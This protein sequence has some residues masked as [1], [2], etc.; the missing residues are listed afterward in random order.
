MPLLHEY[1]RDFLLCSKDTEK[2]CTSDDPTYGN[3]KGNIIGWS[4]FPEQ[5]KC[6]SFNQRGCG[7][8]S[9]GFNTIEECKAKCGK[10]TQFKYEKELREIRFFLL[11]TIR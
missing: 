4:Y 2:T 6:M 1:L 7:L 5:A 3:C 10:Y 11:V 9:T 8:S